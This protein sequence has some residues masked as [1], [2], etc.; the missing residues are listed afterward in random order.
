M[1][2]FKRNITRHLVAILFIAMLSSCIYDSYTDTD[3]GCQIWPDNDGYRIILQ[4][5]SVDGT[6]LGSNIGN[7]HEKVK[8]LRII[9]LNDGAIEYNHYEVLGQTSGGINMSELKDHVVSI[10]TIE[11]SKKF[12]IFANEESVSTLSFA[13]DNSQTNLH[14]YLESVTPNVD[15]VQ[16][17]QN[18][19]KIINAAYFKPEYT[20]DG[21]NIY[22]PYTSYYD[23]FVV[24]SDSPPNTGN[25]LRMEMQMFLVPVATKFVFRFI[26]YRPSEVEI[27][28]ITVSKK[29]THN[30]LFA[31][32]N[33]PDY[34][35]SFEGIDYYWIN[36]LAKVSEASHDNA[37]FY[38]N[39]NF[40][41]KYG[42]ISHYEIPDDS[43]LKDAQFLDGT[44][45]K[46]V[47]A[48]KQIQDSE[49]IEPGAMTLGPF[50]I[51]ESFNSFTTNNNDVS[52]EDVIPQ[53]YYLTLG[54]HDETSVGGRDP[55]FDNVPIDNLK[56]LFRNTCVVIKI[57]MSAGDVEVYAEI[58]P[59][60]IK[61]ANGWLV[62]GNAPSN[63]P[64]TN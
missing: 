36:W 54:I 2:S 48:G 11:G 5:N 32:V 59:W 41:E 47:P 56:A 17:G 57:T 1:T 34:T 23:G 28:D 58:N 30:Y 33:E 35:K 50:Y 18:F 7:D 20:A 14:T 21:G 44:N 9:M 15:D 61:T 43:E 10:N 62:E 6:V 60:N 55:I 45:T 39:V 22:L 37:D 46:T 26:N 42:W 16:A 8:S 19:E 53:R 40:N 63:N 13:D 3:T 25:P 52:D 4:I 24:G 31:R 27:N 64:F 38:D 51:P 12:Y 29:D 49:D